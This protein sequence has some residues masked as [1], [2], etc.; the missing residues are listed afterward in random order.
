MGQRASLLGSRQ[1]VSDGLVST[2]SRQETH[3]DLAAI[4]LIRRYSQNMPADYE[5]KFMTNEWNAMLLDA[6]HTGPDGYHWALRSIS[7]QCELLSC[8]PVP[9]SA[10]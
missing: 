10:V 8:H 7:Q 4:V 6:L 1:W 3:L 9:T 5:G 2:I